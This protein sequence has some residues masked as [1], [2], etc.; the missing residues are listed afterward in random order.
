MSN[1]CVYNVAVGSLLALAGMS[2][3]APTMADYWFNVADA[4]LL[5]YIVEP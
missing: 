5:T 4:S 2:A 1:R 3:S